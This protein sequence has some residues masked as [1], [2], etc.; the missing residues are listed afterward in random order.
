MCDEWVK[1]AEQYSQALNAHKVAVMSLPGLKDRE[2][3]IAWRKTEILGKARDA[4][5]KELQEHQ[6][7]HGC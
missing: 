3:E 2:Y 1:L 6:R 4:A 5:L 7:Q